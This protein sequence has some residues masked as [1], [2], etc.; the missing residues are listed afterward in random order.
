MEWD[1]GEATD[2]VLGLHDTEASRLEHSETAGEGREPVLDDRCNRE[3]RVCSSSSSGDLEGSEYDEE[4]LLDDLRGLG[5]S[6][7]GASSS[8]DVE[9]P[10]VDSKLT[11]ERGSDGGFG[12]LSS[13]T[14]EGGES[15][16]IVLREQE[17]ETSRTKGLRATGDSGLRR[18]VNSKSSTD[19]EHGAILRRLGGLNKLSRSKSSAYS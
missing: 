10:G 18:F 8:I 2:N 6:A 13:G 7:Y 4:L 12:D 17:L 9:M 16:S 15:L 11:V 3:P 19:T 1:D 5:T 14:L